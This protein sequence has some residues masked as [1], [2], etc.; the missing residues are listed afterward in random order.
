[1]EHS[2]ISKTESIEKLQCSFDVAKILQIIHNCGIIHGDI[3]SENVLIFHHPK[4]KFIAKL[5]DFECAVL[6]GDDRDT[7]V[8]TVKEI[9]ILLSK[10]NESLQNREDDISEAIL[11]IFDYTLQVDPDHRSLEKAIDQEILCLRFS[12]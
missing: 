3:K 11:S 12:R 4:R 7:K 6:D 1:M 8:E 2:F 10:V 5:T 9:G